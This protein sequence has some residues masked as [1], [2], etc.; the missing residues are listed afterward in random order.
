MKKIVSINGSPKGKKATS[1]AIL[2]HLNEK[3]EN[4]NRDIYSLLSSKKNGYE[5]LIDKMQDATD[6]LIAFPLYVD[7]IPALLQDFLEEYNKA[8]KNDKISGDKNLYVIINCGF[9]EAEQ[10]MTAMGIM[11]EFA[12][13][14]GFKWRTGVGIGMG[15]MGSGS[16]NR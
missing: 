16:P 4:P 12:R 13:I 10:N 11:K 7:S 9:P 14:S 2:N 8:Y 1:F 3:I 5:K 15:G 6:V